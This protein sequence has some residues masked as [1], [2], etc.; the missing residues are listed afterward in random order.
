MHSARTPTAML[1]TPTALTIPP[2]AVKEHYRCQSVAI[3]SNHR[4]AKLVQP[5][6]RGLIATQPQPV[7]QGQGIDTL[8]GVR[9]LPG[10]MQPRPQRLAGLFEEGTGRHR[11]LPTARSADQQPTARPPGSGRLR[12]S[13][14]SKPLWPPKP[15]K[16][17]AGRLLI[18]KER[19][20]LDETAGENLPLP[21]AHS[22]VARGAS[23]TTA[24]RW[25]GPTSG[26][27][28]SSGGNSGASFPGP[29]LLLI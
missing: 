3:G 14:A 26:S 6:P 28:P 13:R 15:F 12:A 1:T 7:L 20:E 5:R 25:S 23:Q 8:R 19:L 24:G 17:P 16:V 18:R 21:L 9:D 10:D 22:M 29:S 4:P 2:F 11:N 27:V